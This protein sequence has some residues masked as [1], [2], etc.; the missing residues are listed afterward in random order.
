MEI[1][2]SPVGVNTELL[3]KT[4]EL[5]S[6]SIVFTDPSGNITYVNAAF[7]RKTGYRP[8]EV[9]GRNP[10]ILKSGTQPPSVYEDLWRT[11]RSGD[12][13]TGELLNRR[14]D[15]SLF[16]EYATI[17]PIL[18]EGQRIANYVAI[19]EDITVRKRSEELLARFAEANQILLESANLD[20]SILRILQLFGE[21]CDV[22]RSCYYAYTESVSYPKVGRLSLVSEWRGPEDPASDR[23]TDR[24]IHINGPRLA[25]WIGRLKDR[26]SV[27]SR[28]DQLAEPE[29]SFFENERIRSML[30]V[31][32]QS[33]DHLAGLVAFIDCG[34]Q[35]DWPEAEVSLLQS[36]AG[37]IGI[38]LQKKSYERDI[39]EA[40]LKA[41]ESAMEAIQ[42]NAAKS[43]FLA[44]M[45][46]EIRTPLNGILGMTQILLDEALSP[47]HRDFINTIHRSG[48]SLHNLLN[49]VLDFSKMEAGKLE[50][51]EASFSLVSLAGEMV[52][53]YRPRAAE[54]AITLQARIDPGFPSSVRGDPDRIRQVL[55]N[56]VSNAVKFTERG[57]VEIRLSL[58]T[59]PRP[60]VRIEVRDSGI[61][62]DPGFGPRLFQLFTQADSSTTRKFGG[63]GLG[64]A[65]SRR[66]VEAMNGRIWFESEPGKGSVFFVD[67]PIRAGDGSG[68]GGRLIDAPERPGPARRLDP[69]P[70][71][72]V[73]EDNLINRRVT[74]LQLRSLEQTP[75]LAENGE[76]AVRL[77]KE[78]GPFDLIFMDCQ[79]PNKNG[80]DAAEEILKDAPSP[81]PYIVALTAAATPPDKLRAKE[82]GMRD[83]LIKPVDKETLREA[84]HR[85]KAHARGA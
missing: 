31:P 34:E 39:Q 32:I 26:R 18:D 62:I 30:M 85:Y 69:N 13:W 74:E 56:L 49:D 20:R 68:G 17:F 16:W 70:R 52:D 29:R 4:L 83:Y 36:V 2:N 76:E 64:L 77:C 75:V 61:G 23:T 41:E 58:P 51:R 8:D 7:T 81:P 10:S 84:I 19:K 60:C 1:K 15:G 6:G 27:K 33:E 57:G 48:E 21:A 44:T 45:S 24:T 12:T 38:V 28:I 55:S 14:K 35:R 66:L 59:D 43:T 46:H 78:K 53:L 22:D 50:I 25:D 63:T 47:E 72:L 5:S 79:M 9:I 40:L 71:I 82:V 37:S 54:K 42:A 3:E 65:I 73:V 67:L 80:F 11:I